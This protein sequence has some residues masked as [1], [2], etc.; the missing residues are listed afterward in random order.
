MVA[1]VFESMQ[2]LKMSSLEISLPVSLL[3][4]TKNSGLE[5]PAWRSGTGHKQQAYPAEKLSERVSMSCMIGAL[6]N[7]V[8]FATCRFVV[9]CLL[10][11]QAS[12]DSPD[13]VLPNSSLIFTMHIYDTGCRA[14]SY[15]QNHWPCVRVSSRIP[16][17][18][19]L[20]AHG[21]GYDDAFLAITC[22][23]NWLL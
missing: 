17:I 8:V 2:S 14:A 7:A 13:P 18:S 22:G 3:V 11:E 12:D 1:G 5:P 23:R 21:Y 16:K 4:M 6:L 15:G 10:S 19:M 20:Y 9:H